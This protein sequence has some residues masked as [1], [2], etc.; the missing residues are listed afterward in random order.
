MTAEALL[1]AD[2]YTVSFERG[3]AAAAAFFGRHGFV[4]IRGAVSDAQCEATVGEIF[5][6]LAGTVPGF[7][8]AEPQS[9]DALSSKT[10][11]LPPEQSIC[12]PQLLAN[13][14]AE[15]VL[16]AFECGPA[17]RLCAARLMSCRR[18]PGCSL[19]RTSWW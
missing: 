8:L 2:G 1:D 10:Y 13:R 3:D 17:R 19:E 16:E 6:Y 18:R 4:V 7:E 12:L 15:G 9:W 11:G 5:E 14:Q